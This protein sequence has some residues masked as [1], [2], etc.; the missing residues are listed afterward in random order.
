MR[1]FLIASMLTLTLAP[2]A[3]I[4]LANGGPAPLLQA[5]PLDHLVDTAAAGLRLTDVEITRSPSRIRP[6]ALTDRLTCLSLDLSIRVESPGAEPQ[7]L[8]PG[9]ACDLAGMPAESWVSYSIA[10]DEPPHRV[11]LADCLAESDSCWQLNLPFA[12]MIELS[13]LGA[14]PRLV[15][16]AAQVSLLR[17]QEPAPT[18]AIEG[19]S[20]S[21]FEFPEAT[22]TEEGLLLWHLRKGWAEPLHEQVL[23]LEESPN[24]TVP[25]VGSSLLWVAL[26]DGSSG[27]VRVEAQPGEQIRVNVPLQSRPRLCGRLLDWEG[28]PVAGE[29]VV[30]TTALD[31]ADYDFRP[32]DRFGCVAYRRSGVLHHS[33][34]KTY[35][36]DLEGRFAIT[37]PRGS[38]YALYSHALNGYVFWNGDAAAAFA[39][40]G[41]PIEI[42]LMRRCPENEARVTLL[43]P[44]G[45]PI[46]AAKVTVTVAGDVP[47]F[48]Q[49]PGTLVTDGEGQLSV[50]GLEPGMQIGLLFRH[51][52]LKA[53]A[54]APVYPVVPADRRIVIQVPWEVLQG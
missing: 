48:R 44:D 18:T 40:H 1:K 17:I 50:M 51:E 33:V 26:E 6:L 34:K 46:D 28:N 35:T 39:S 27:L 53:G 19:N 45:S 10:P 29:K 38:S 15:E 7:D 43:K 2:L 47:Y 8:L 12:C 30:M 42:R 36:T 24:L 37:V 52:T 31:L 20:L 11:R 9:E 54:Y 22:M 4:W 49:W 25:G 21:I 23:R 5:A 16:Q 41:T 32:N 14:V 13:L 3:L